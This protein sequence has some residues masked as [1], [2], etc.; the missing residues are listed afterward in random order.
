MSDLKRKGK[1]MECGSQ[2][3]GLGAYWVSGETAKYNRNKCQM[4]SKNYYGWMG[5]ENS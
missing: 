2:R 4:N 1:G 3:M 5:V